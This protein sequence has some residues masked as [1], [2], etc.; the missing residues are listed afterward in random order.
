MIVH[1]GSVADDQGSVVLSL[2]LAEVLTIS[3][4]LNE[5]VE[6]IS[7]WEFHVRTGVE[8]AEAQR[9]HGE[10]RRLLHP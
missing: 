9:L 4:A 1:S 5:A 10:I 8:R 6:A 2:D 3:N 7:D